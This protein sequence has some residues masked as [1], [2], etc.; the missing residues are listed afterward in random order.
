MTDK[1]PVM[2]HRFRS[3]HQTAP[4][5]PLS[6]DDKFIDADKIR[7]RIDPKTGEPLRVL[8]AHAVIL[9]DDGSTGTEHWDEDGRLYM[10]S[11]RTVPYPK[12]W[13]AT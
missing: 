3:V 8:P 7:Y 6:D 9:N 12:D 1:I 5:P 2:V 4:W 11:Y 10:T 13:K